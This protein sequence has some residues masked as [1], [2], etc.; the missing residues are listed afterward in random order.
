MKNKETYQNLS[1]YVS[2]R[3]SLCVYVQNQ[4]YY[5]YKYECSISVKK[6]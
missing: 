1:I 5:I 2:M 3:I 4:D 6:K